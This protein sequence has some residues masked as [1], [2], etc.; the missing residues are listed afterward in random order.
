[1]ANP[2]DLSF[3]CRLEATHKDRWTAT[4]PIAMKDVTWKYLLNLIEMSKSAKVVHILNQMLTLDHRKIEAFVRQMY[5]SSIMCPEMYSVLYCSPQVHLEPLYMYYIC[6]TSTHIKLTN[7]VPY[8]DIA[9]AFC[10]CAQSLKCPNMGKTFYRAEEQSIT[11]FNVAVLCGYGIDDRL[12]LYNSSS[13]I[14]NPA[15]NAH[16]TNATLD[17]VDRYNNGRWW[18][19]YLLLDENSRELLREKIGDLFRQL[20]YLKGSASHSNLIGVVISILMLGGKNML[21]DQNDQ[22]LNFLNELFDSEALS[23]DPYPLGAKQKSYVM[24]AAPSGTYPLIYD[25]YT[26]IY[27]EEYKLFTSL[28][29]IIHPE[30]LKDEI[31]SQVLRSFSCMPILGFEALHLFGECLFLYVIRSPVRIYS[32]TLISLLNTNLH[33]SECVM[34]MLLYGYIMNREAY[35][36]RPRHG[37]TR[38][39]VIDRIGYIMNFTA[40]ES[41]S[42]SWERSLCCGTCSN[43]TTK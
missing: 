42:L 18:D 2:F 4:N 34:G 23:I 27:R 35:R 40:R 25:P 12:Y 21:M 38:D 22:C 14:K 5:N 15:F 16:Y 8:H 10:Q 19:Q 7:V 1:M 37:I 30:D 17:F 3:S 9:L 28:N 41:Y 32:E 20:V 6:S 33:K 29:W 43:T 24:N 31:M 11:L 13:Q 36:E 26:C 39:E